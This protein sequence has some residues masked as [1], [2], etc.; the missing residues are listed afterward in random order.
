[1]QSR[2]QQ[3]LVLRRIRLNQTGEV[4]PLRP[5]VVLPSLI[6]RTEELE[7]ARSLRPWDVPLEARAEVFGRDAMDGDRAGRA[8]G[9]PNLVGT[10]IQAAEQMPRQRVAEEKITWRDNAEGWAPTTVGG[11]G[12]LGIRVTEH[13]ARAALQPADGELA[14]EAAAVFPDDQPKSVC[15]DG[16][17]ATGE[18]WRT[19]VPRIPRIRWLPQSI[20]NIRDRGRGAWRRKLLAKAWRVSQAGDTRRVAP[21]TR[22]VR[23]GSPIHLTGVAATRVEKLCARGGSLLAA[24]DCPG[25]AGTSNAGGRLVHLG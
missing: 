1:S 4:F 14:G 21:R 9:R 25:A 17:A 3:D 6:G 22:R 7:T 15:T 23:E 2:Q 5:S 20:L 10:T 19:L 8:F 16:W 12:H 11:G 24:D 13:E 18:A